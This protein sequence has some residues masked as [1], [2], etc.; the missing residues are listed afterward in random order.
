MYFNR[1]F[2]F[3]IIGSIRVMPERNTDILLNTYLFQ[4]VF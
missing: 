3:K 4:C 2:K 1:L